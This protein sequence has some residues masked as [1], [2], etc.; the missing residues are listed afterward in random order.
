MGERPGT[1]LSLEISPD[2]WPCREPD[3]GLL[4][5]KTAENKFVVWVTQ[6]VVLSKAAL[7]N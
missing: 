6:P 5:F 1:H 4:A 3:L 7:E 2:A